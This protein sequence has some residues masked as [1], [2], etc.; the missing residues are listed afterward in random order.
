MAGI[1]ALAQNVGVGLMFGSFGVLLA[2]V[3]KAMEVG[4]DVSVL[5]M[6]LVM[7]G[8]SLLGPVVGGLSTRFT[9][10]SLM[11]LGALLTAAGYLALSFAT[12]IALNLAAYALLIGPGF[13]FLSVVLPSALTARWFVAGRGRALGIV[14]MPIFVML[15]PLVVTALLAHGGLALAYRAMALVALALVPI[16]WFI[17]E[18]P[19]TAS[20][21]EPGDAPAQP[22]HGLSTA[23]LATSATYWKMTIAAAAI[24]TGGTIISTHIVPLAMGWGVASGQAALLV[25]IMAGAGMAGSLAF[26]WLADRVGGGRALMINCVSQILLWGLL[27]L[28]PG[29]ALLAILIA[30]IGVCG[31]GL[32][33]AFGTALAEHFGPASFGRAYGFSNLVNLPFIAGGAPLAGL[34]FVRTGSYAA[35]LMGQMGFFLFAAL[36]VASVRRRA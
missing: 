21:A 18:H 28:Q 33:A 7:I 4:R 10:R 16:L 36:L 1:A 5:G 26:G 14:N 24:A 27:L 12:T 9:I 22:D 29:Y 6:P 31:A 13:V 25:T 19:P 2:P 35:A 30:L 32:V 17:V 8:M 23:A 11:I 34:I 15:T 20:E 3:E